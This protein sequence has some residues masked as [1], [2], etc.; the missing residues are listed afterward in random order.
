MNDSSQILI[1]IALYF[2]VTFSLFTIAR[3]THCETAVLAFV[4]LLQVIPLVQAANKS[5]L[6]ILLLL[7]PLVNIV[8]IVLIWMGIAEARGKPGLIGLLMLVPVLN[9][10]VIGYLAYAD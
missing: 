7:I 10:G 5:L 4:P 2:Y 8:A 3:K 9:L 6:W 1:S